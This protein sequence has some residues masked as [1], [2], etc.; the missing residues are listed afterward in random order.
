M[1]NA[2]PQFRRML[3]YKGTGPPGGPLLSSTRNVLADYT[4]Y[5]HQLQVI[6][7]AHRWGVGKV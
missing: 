1:P 2:L 5:V 4:M 6:A 3:A 7:C